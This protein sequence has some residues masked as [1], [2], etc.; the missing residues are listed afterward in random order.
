[1]SVSDL[2]G[3]PASRQTEIVSELVDAERAYMFDLGAPPLLRFA[4]Q[5]RADDEFQWTITEHHAILDGWS[6][7]APLPAA[8]LGMVAGTKLRGRLDE[9]AFRRTFFVS[10]LMIAIYMLYRGAGR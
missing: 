4:I 5:I 9:R 2:C 6:L 8:M 1:V 3:L 7:A 10:L